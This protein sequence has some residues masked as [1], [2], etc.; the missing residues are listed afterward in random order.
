[1]GQSG[2]RFYLAVYRRSVKAHE[3]L[4]RF[5][6]RANDF[7]IRELVDLMIWGT[8]KLCLHHLVFILAKSA[9][10]PSGQQGFCSW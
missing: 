8:A 10:T 2:S 7:A 4:N 3:C 9:Y 5:G 6:V 1:M